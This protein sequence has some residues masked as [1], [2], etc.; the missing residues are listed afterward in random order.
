MTDKK[1]MG[2]ILAITVIIANILLFGDVMS[3]ID[4]IGSISIFYI[5]HPSFVILVF[6]PFLAVAFI[7]FPFSD[8]YNESVYDYDENLLDNIEWKRNG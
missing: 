5:I 8:V 7:I 4:M 2:I 1:T 6:I 3:F